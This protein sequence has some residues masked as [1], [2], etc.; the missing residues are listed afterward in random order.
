MQPIY[1]LENCV[2]AYQL[3]WSVS[4][5]ARQDLPPAAEWFEKLQSV[6]EPDGVRLLEYRTTQANVGQ[7]FV[8]TRPP[9]SPSDM[10]RSI[11]GRWR[12]LLRQSAA[13]DFRRNY[14]MISVG[15]ANREV[16]DR[17]VAGQ[18]GRHKM[19]DPRVENLLAALQFHDPAVEIDA[20][21]TGTYGQF[22]QALQVVV[23]NEGGWNETRADT[24]GKSRDMILRAAVRK[25][26]RVSRIAMLANHIH[27]LLAATVTESPGSVAISLMNN[28]AYVQGMT[29]C[30][31]FSYYVGTFGRYD[32]DA[33]RRRL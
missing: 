23:E 33:I 16:L 21:Q 4:L 19:A 13:V 3:N 18:T 11:K 31:K 25:G 30:L 22:C 26:W 14:S 10:I 32:R 8:S 6:T 29:P 1:T 20:V 15:E 17:Y 9:V 7:F 24:L 12:H 27:V 5:F 28:L 2:P